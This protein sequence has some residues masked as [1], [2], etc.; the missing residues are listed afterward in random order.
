MRALFSASALALALCAAQPAAAHGSFPE[1]RQLVADPADPAHLWLRATYGVLVSP[2][3]GASWR[4]TCSNA[5]GYG[6]TESPVLRATP[7]GALSIA[8]FDAILRSTDQGCSFATPQSAPDGANDLASDPNDPTRLVAVTSRGVGNGAFKSNLWESKDSGASYQQIGA[9][10][11][12]GALVLG[13]ALAPS[14]GNRL[15]LG[16]L[17]SDADAGTS[18]AAGIL[19]S[20]DAG[21]SFTHYDVPVA[22]GSPVYLLGVA[23]GDADTLYLRAEALTPDGQ[24]TLQSLWVTGDGGASFSKVLEKH[25]VLMGFTFTPDGKSVL[26]GFGDPQGTTVVDPADLGLYS[27]PLGSAAFSLVHPHHFGCLT[28]VGSDLYACMSQFTDDYE[29]GRSSDGGKTFSGLL[30]L[31]SFEP[32]DDC[33]PSTTYAGVCPNEW[34]D[35]V[36]PDLGRCVEGAAGASSGGDDAGGGGCGCATRSRAP[37][38]AA[39]AL[40]ALFLLGLRRRRC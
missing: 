2:D 6:A 27:A 34:T 29:L 33:A 30:K 39:L 35:D 23:P 18:S 20:G 25:A 5:A 13:V 14:D 32:A 12:P 15:Y 36:C 4:W 11:D 8:N 22:A 37:F 40:G 16:G 3:S 7:D 38:G 28:W 19:R 24:P 10:L 1:G 26:V 9:D 21:Q 31:D 17:F